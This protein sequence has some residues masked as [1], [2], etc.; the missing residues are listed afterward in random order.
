MLC[1]STS[2][3][4]QC[5][6]ANLSANAPRRFEGD[7]VHVYV[8]AS[9]KDGG[10]SGIGGVLHDS[11]GIVKS[12]FSEKID[13]ELVQLIR[14]KGQVTIIQELEMLSLLVAVQFWCLKWTGYRLVAFTDSEAVRG[15]FLKTWTH[16]GLNNMLLARI[17]ELEEACNS[18]IWLERVPSQSNP[19]DLF[20]RE[21]VTV[22]NG[23]RNDEVDPKAV[24]L[25]V[26]QCLG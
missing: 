24:W 1:A 3:A 21:K 16:N 19:A 9:L 5:M 10:C 8:D 23:L 20:S 22:W 26:A 11:A 15:S 18:Q 7:P 17:F 6:R 2:A 13:E 25:S 12:F 14:K 4:L